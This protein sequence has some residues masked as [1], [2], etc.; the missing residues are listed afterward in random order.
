MSTT[1]TLV[2]HPGQ[3]TVAAV[4]AVRG[5][6]RVVVAY[7]MA[8][9]APG[10]DTA[11]VVVN[12]ERFTLEERAVAL[13]RLGKDL[14]SRCPGRRRL[15]VGRA[16]MPLGRARDWLA[17]V[18]VEVERGFPYSTMRRIS[19]DPARVL[20][21]SDTIVLPSR[22][23]TVATDGS[24]NPATRAASA[25]F[26]TDAGY[27][28]ARE[29]P[30]PSGRIVDAETTAICMVLRAFPTHD[31]VVLTDSQAA[32]RIIRQALDTT[33]AHPSC[34]TRALENVPYRLRAPVRKAVAG[35]RGRVEIRWVPGHSGQVLNE[36]ADRLVRAVRRESEGSATFRSAERV[37]RNIRREILT[38]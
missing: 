32:R 23:I 35:H 5:P 25:G 19:T 30:C 34:P 11:Y 1:E 27:A 10:A 9:A 36:A 22:T 38:T 18:D 17:G 8:V 37:R 3:E 29:C 2:S 20:A 33:E 14:V 15:F 31:L 6:D 24:L 13:Q 16:G 7:L 28:Y 12:L 26:V 21:R 4:V